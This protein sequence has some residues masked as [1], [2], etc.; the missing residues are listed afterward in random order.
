MQAP[1]SGICGWAGGEDWGTSR[2][3]PQILLNI[4]GFCETPET[5]CGFWQPQTGDLGDSLLSL[6]LLASPSDNSSLLLTPASPGA[7]HVS[8]VVPQYSVPASSLLRCSVITSLTPSV[9]LAS[10]LAC[11][12]HLTM[13]SFQCYEQS[14]LFQFGGWGNCGSEGWKNLSKVTQ[15]ERGLSQSPCSYTTVLP[16]SPHLTTSGPRSPSTQNGG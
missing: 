14:L 4:G 8:S 16:Q 7:G 13:F 6:T 1:L 15:L 2:V 5:P 12:I 3:C 10:G 11:P 9:C